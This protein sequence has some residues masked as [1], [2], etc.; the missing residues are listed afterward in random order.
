LIRRYNKSEIRLAFND[1]RVKTGTSSTGRPALAFN[2][3]H[4]KT[5]YLP[6]MYIGHDAKLASTLP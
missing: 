3:A 5:P 4:I 1:S 2:P 6:A